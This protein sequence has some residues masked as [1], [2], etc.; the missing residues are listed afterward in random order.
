MKAVDAD[1]ETKLSIVSRGEWKAKEPRAKSRLPHPVEL[2]LVRDEFIAPCNAPDEC[3]QSVRKVQEAHLRNPYGLD[4]DANFL[5]AGDGRVYEGRGWDVV[6]DEVHRGLVV[7]FVGRYDVILPSQ[8]QIDAFNLLI[9]EGIKRG[10][11]SPYYKLLAFGQLHLKGYPGKRL[12]E[13][14]KSWDHWA[15]E[16]T[17][18]LPF[19]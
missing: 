5:I 18:Q 10:E 7:S 19:K 8:S 1:I 16:T 4:I 13:F 11:I 2:V 3:I 14:I 12:F 15:D 17:Q 9:R 6:V